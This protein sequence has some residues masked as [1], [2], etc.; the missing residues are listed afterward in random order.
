M[1]AR[2]RYFRPPREYRA[3]GNRKKTLTVVRFKSPTDMSV[4][5]APLRSAV[6]C[7][8]TCRRRMC[9][10]GKSRSGNGDG[11]T[12]P[13]GTSGRLCV[14]QGYCALFERARHLHFGAAVNAGHGK[15]RLALHGAL[16]LARPSGDRVKSPAF[17]RGGDVT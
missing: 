8:C 16:E 6:A 5:G 15:T 14:R 13:G 9:G 1:D 3:I 7:T 2:A 12:I 11:R 10:E 17:D 4:D